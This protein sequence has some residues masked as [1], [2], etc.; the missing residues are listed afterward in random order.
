R[1]E[2][3]SDLATGERTAG[4]ASTGAEARTRDAGAHP[5]PLRGRA[6]WVRVR[7]ANESAV[8]GGYRQRRYAA[9]PRLATGSRRQTRIFDRRSTLTEAIACAVDERTDTNKARL[10]GVLDDDS[11]D[12]AFVAVRSEA[13]WMYSSRS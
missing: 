7:E 11:I 6:V 5:R 1:R 13:R 8:S 12:D 10:V 2:G 3:A 4:G 9:V